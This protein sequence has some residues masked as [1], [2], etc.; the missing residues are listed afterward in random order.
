M[1]YRCTTILILYPN[2]L[3]YKIILYIILTYRKLFEINYIKL[4]KLINILSHYVDTKTKWRQQ[5]P[6][7]V[8]FD[9]D[10]NFTK[11][12]RRND[13]TITVWRRRIVLPKGR[14]STVHHHPVPRDGHTAWHDREL[15]RRR[16]PAHVLYRARG[17]GVVLDGPERRRSRPSL[18][19]VGYFGHGRAERG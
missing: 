9:D 3:N 6:V 7:F 10:N 19:H 1:R 4:V 18:V 17:P 8:V 2:Y 14:W 15:R 13:Q 16:P 12:R 5:S 11:T